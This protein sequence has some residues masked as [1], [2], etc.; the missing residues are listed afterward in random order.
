ME[1]LRSEVCFALAC[2]GFNRIDSSFSFL[3]TESLLL[4]DLG[5]YGHSLSVC[6]SV[7]CALHLYIYIYVDDSSAALALLTPAVKQIY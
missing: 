3:A 4:F 7:C 1:L 5:Y 2:E 6:F